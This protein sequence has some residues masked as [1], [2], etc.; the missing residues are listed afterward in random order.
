[1]EIHTLYPSIAVSATQL[2]GIIDVGG[3]AAAAL[4]PSL[5]PFSPGDSAH[6]AAILPRGDLPTDRPSH[7]AAE[8]EEEVFVRPLLSRRRMS[9]LCPGRRLSVLLPDDWAILGPP[10]L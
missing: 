6:S 2:L 10:I 5:L 9:R 7:L 8:E 1:M 3:D 4:P